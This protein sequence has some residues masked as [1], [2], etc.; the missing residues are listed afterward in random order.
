MRFEKITKL[1]EG[2]WLKMYVARYINNNNQVKDYEVISRDNDL[3]EHPEKFGPAT[4][5]CAVGIIAT[6]EDNTKI[7]INKEF[8][9]ACNEWVY[10]FPGGILE[11]DE[12]VEQAA[13]REL[14][15]ETGLELYQIDKVLGKA[16]TAVGV[17]NECVS[18]LIGKARGEFKP[19]TSADEE[20]EAAW[21]T[22]EEIKNLIDNGAVMSLRTQSYL[23]M[24]SN[25]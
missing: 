11:P 13:A 15:E 25:N 19:S 3:E 2:K 4:Q 10:E 24:W 17:A 18:T 7:L 21:Y 1:H 8:R 14:Q 12:T 20:I 23:Y 6:N 22:K 16:Y 9:L 5:S